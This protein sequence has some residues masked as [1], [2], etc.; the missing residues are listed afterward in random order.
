MSLERLK[1]I[2]ERVSLLHQ[3]TVLTSFW[4]FYLT[5]TEEERIND[6]I[7]NYY[8]DTLDRLR[9]KETEIQSKLERGNKDD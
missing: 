9:A 8:T 5:N 7:S 6:K 3:M 1:L 4:M 2:D